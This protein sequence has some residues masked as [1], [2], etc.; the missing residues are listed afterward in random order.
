MFYVVAFACFAISGLILLAFA[1][2][3]LTRK[4]FM[5]YHREAVG[6]AWSE[7]DPRIQVLLI[8][9][10]RAAGGMMLTAGIAYAFI[11]FIPFRVGE[12]WAPYALAI[13]GFAACLTGIF[14][15]SYVKKHTGAH[16]PVAGSY[17][18][19]VLSVVGLISSLV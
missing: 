17:V 13:A 12:P 19:L 1:V 11:L 18:A 6:K 5:P 3:Y 10:M 2:A 4:E 8:G 16:P 9:L 14:A 15:M 7:L